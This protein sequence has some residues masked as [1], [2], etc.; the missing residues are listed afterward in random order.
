MKRVGNFSILDTGDNENH[1]LYRLGAD[2]ILWRSKIGE[3]LKLKDTSS[4][5]EKMEEFANRYAYHPYSRWALKY[6]ALW[7]RLIVCDGL[8]SVSKKTDNDNNYS[9]CPYFVLG[10]LDDEL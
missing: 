4:A 8:W 5:G 9:P 6:I 2:H 3:E 10:L 7:R 1:L